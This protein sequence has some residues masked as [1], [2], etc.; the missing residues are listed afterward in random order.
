[1]SEHKAT[2]T[3][4]RDPAVAFTYKTYSR[5][6]GWDFGEG[7]TIKA[8]AATDFLGDASCVDPEQAY[9][10]SLSSCHM[11]TFLAICSLQKLTVESYVDDAVGHLEKGATGKPELTRVEL[12]PKTV[13][14]DGVVV[15]AE[16]L[17]ELHD[18][19]HHECFLANSVKT[20]ITT[21]LD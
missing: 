18:K 9:V 6:H 2:L 1:M 12:H 10:A 8:S 21:I 5:N 16:K 13:F 17:A 4:M 3:W 20:Q 19:A 14:A 11:L 7:N 15:S